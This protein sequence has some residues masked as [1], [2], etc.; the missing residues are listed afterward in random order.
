MLAISTQERET[1]RSTERWRGKMERKK[2]KERKRENERKREE[3]SER[4]SKKEGNREQVILS[5]L[6]KIVTVK[7]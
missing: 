4:K 6:E 1:K 7:F 2:E 5:E 3:E